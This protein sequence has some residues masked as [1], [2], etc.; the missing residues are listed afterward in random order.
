[1]SKN[2]LLNSPKVVALLNVGFCEL[3][4]PLKIQAGWPGFFY[5]GLMTDFLFL[6]GGRVFTNPPADVAGVYKY[7]PKEYSEMS[8]T[9]N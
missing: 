2:G 5:Q 3:T 8:S 1:M 4:V 7:V 6:N 9:F